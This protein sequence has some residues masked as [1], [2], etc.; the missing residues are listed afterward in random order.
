[1][2]TRKRLR[3]FQQHVSTRELHVQTS[4]EIAER[5]RASQL[6]KIYETRRIVTRS[7]ARHCNST[8]AVCPQIIVMTYVA[9]IILKTQTHIDGNTEAGVGFW[10][11]AAAT[12]HIFNAFYVFQAKS[13]NI[14]GWWYTKLV[15]VGIFRTLG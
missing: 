1:M 5:V 14:F 15:A 2:E 10:R 13:T 7:S 3:T 4:Y 12:S 8:T 9:A 6:V 11:T